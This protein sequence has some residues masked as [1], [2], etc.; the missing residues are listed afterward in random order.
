MTGFVR[1]ALRRFC[2]SEDGMALVPFALW[3]PFIVGLTLSAIEL[4][5]STLR[6]STLDRALDESVRHVKLATGRLVTPEQLKAEICERAPVL[7]SCESMLQLEMVR[8][9]M[10]DWIVPPA[11]VAC[12]DTG[13]PVNPQRF[14]EA[15]QGHDVMLLRACYKYR[16][17][18]PGGYLTAALSKDDD[19]YTAL[20][21]TTAFVAEPL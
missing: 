13:L 12:V 5:A 8:L 1:T 3:M 2:R 7:L 14:F 10:R 18:G 6:Q 9:D 11:Q 17:I 16:P 15:G 20:T 4:G 21:S 19:G